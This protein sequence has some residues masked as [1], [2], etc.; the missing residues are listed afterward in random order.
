MRSLIAIS[1]AILLSG[2]A[3]RAPMVASMTGDG[4]YWVLKEPLEYEQPETKQRFVVPRG[5][6]T[7]L[8]S[9]PR[10]FWSAFPPCGRYTPAAVVH[11]YLYWEHLPSCDRK[12]ADR[13]L[14][15]AMKESKVGRFSRWAIYVGVHRAGQS[16]WDNNAAEKAAGGLRYVPEEFLNFG[17]K[18]TWEQ[19]ERRIRSA[20]SAAR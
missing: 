14:F 11:D 9:V 19:I 5:F 6:V 2:C 13:L 17:P 18:D 20:K 3:F 7:D 1:I 10:V 8:A 12:C 16:S 4:K 15:V